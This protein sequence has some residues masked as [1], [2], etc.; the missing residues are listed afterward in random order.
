MGGLRAPGAPVTVH[1][2]FTERT[3]RLTQVFSRFTPRVPHLED[4]SVG[5]ERARRDRSRPARHPAEGVLRRQQVLLRPDVRPPLVRGDVDE[6]CGPG[7]AVV[8]VRR[9]LVVRKEGRER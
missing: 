8:G 2:R 5:H 1:A 7:A 4:P 6:V 9:R 3:R